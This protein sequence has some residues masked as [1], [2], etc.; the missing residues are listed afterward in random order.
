MTDT[1]A[2]VMTGAPQAQPKPAET[3]AIPKARPPRRRRMMF[4]LI[5]TAMA[6]GAAAIIFIFARP[7]CACSVP[8]IKPCGCALP[9]IAPASLRPAAGPGDHPAPIKSLRP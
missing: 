4:A 6:F 3:A 8:D 7:S 1:A 9:P 2:F 5:A